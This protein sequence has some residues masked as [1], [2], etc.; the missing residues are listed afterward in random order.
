M[1]MYMH[2]LRK[3]EAEDETESPY[4][5]WQI[6]GMHVIV[7]LRQKVLIYELFLK[8]QY[9]GPLTALALYDNK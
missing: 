3:G 9:A 7:F 5:W 4:Q 1:Y 2:I 6:Y 8:S